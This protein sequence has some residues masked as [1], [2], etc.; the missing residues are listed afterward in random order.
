MSK[1]QTGFLVYWAETPEILGRAEKF[2]TGIPQFILR[3]V[4]QVTNTIIKV[5]FI[6]S[7]AADF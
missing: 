4:Q 7:E 2:Q 5:G 3:G 6:A 1:F